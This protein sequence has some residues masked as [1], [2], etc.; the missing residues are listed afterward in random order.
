MGQTS[1]GHWYPWIKAQLEKHNY[2]V[3]VPDLPTPDQPD[4]RKMTE[5]LLARKDWD[6]TD[7]LLIG[8]SSGAV[9]ILHLLPK[10]STRVMAAVLL[11]SFDH[12]LW[13]KQHAMLFADEIDYAAAKQKA[14]SFI[15]M[16]GDDDPWC[17]LEGAKYIAD[18]LAADFVVVHGAGHFSTSLDPSF[19]QNMPLMEV[20]DTK[21]LI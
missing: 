4:A 20:L 1:K 5:F 16:H 21:E 8:H 11:G 2:D 13:E 15:V 19:S 3:W 18:E 10:L 6:W 7:N 14:D 17:P 12:P 9:E